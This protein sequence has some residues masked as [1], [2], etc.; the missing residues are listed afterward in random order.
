[1]IGDAYLQQR[2]ELD[3]VLFSL[4]LTAGEVRVPADR[5]VALHRLQESLREPFFFIVLGPG[6]AGKSTLLNALFGREFFSTGEPQS[7]DRIRL[8]KY[9][10]EEKDEGIDGFATECRRPAAF[11]RMFNVLETPPIESLGDRRA[12]IASRFAPAADAVWLVLPAQG[13]DVPGAA[14]VVESIGAELR[15]RTIVVIQQAD[16]R[17]E[18]D[19]ARMADDLRKAI[20]ERTGAECPVF[21]VSARHALE[22]KL[23]GDPRIGGGFIE[24]EKHLS[25]EIAGGARHWEKLRNVADAAQGIVKDMAVQVEVS[26]QG[27]QRD[28]RRIEQLEA[29]LAEQKAAT[30]RQIETLLWDI[31]DAYEKTQKRGEESIAAKLS[32]GSALGLALNRVE[33]RCQF[34]QELE[35]KLG[36]KVRKQ[37]AGALEWLEADLSGVWKQLHERIRAE[38][39]DVAPPRA[40]VPPPPSV[41]PELQQQIEPL[42]EAT[43]AYQKVELHI[44]QAL[45]GTAKSLRILGSLATAF[46][47]GAA[48]TSLTHL[49]IGGILAAVAVGFVIAAMALVGVRKKAMLAEYRTYVAARRETLL[50][51]IEAPVRKA[52]D[53]IYTQLAPAFTPLRTWCATRRGQYDPIAA[54]IRELAA[55]LGKFASPAAASPAKEPAKTD[56][57]AP[58]SEVKTAS[59]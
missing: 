26:T 34:Q 51:G 33:P 8:F 16:V 46:G 30:V 40:Q 29:A 17:S 42:M 1:M 18:G 43:D 57:P 10:E 44:G 49:G 24:M 15:K 19:I 41:R 50:N 59:P 23:H 58:A 20:R 9:G 55:T 13:V 38:F 54:R 56:A 28:T 32:P 12:G 14:A 36:E 22:A 7:D 53:G 39:P 5:L 31:A 2:A 37:V 6:K 47:V 52:A 45:A 35:S 48:A 27:V 21:A 4:Q 3:N 25:D 11:L